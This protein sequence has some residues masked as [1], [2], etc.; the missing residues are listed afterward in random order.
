M[1]IE[2]V[3]ESDEGEVF[4]HNSPKYER[5][6]ASVILP[7]VADEFRE[8]RKERLHISRPHFTFYLDQIVEVAQALSHRSWSIHR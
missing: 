6:H 1:L 2:E 4:I 7:F 3:K 5:R 8:E